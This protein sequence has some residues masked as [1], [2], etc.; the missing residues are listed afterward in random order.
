VLVRW[1]L[2]PMLLLTS[3]HPAQ[4]PHL[5]DIHNV[6]TPTAAVS[7]TRMLGGES[8]ELNA[9]L[10]QPPPPP[11]NR[12]RS[13]DGALDVSVGVY[14]DCTGMAEVTHE[15]AAIDTCLG[16]RLYFIGHNPG[17]FTPLRGFG[18]G[19]EI[20]YYDDSGLAH[21]WRIVETRTWSRW[22]GSPPLATSGVVA[23][24]QTCI[25]ADGN[26]DEILDAVPV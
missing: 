1:L 10:R 19:S 5:A 23:Q 18:T 15:G 24:F 21:T 4:S 14:N 9:Q 22:A 12:L 6:P 3:L 7:A 20:T 11:R 17:P 2:T 13:D 25:T 26:W 8:A 16:G